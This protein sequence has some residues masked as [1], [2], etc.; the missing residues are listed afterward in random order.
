MFNPHQKQHLLRMEE[1]LPGM[2]IKIC[3]Y[4]NHKITSDK[5][6]KVTSLPWA[7]FDSK[8]GLT[9]MAFYGILEGEAEV[10]LIRTK[11]AYLDMTA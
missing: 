3:D 11:Y 9:V 6:C 7:E 5:S 10:T 8:H 2:H 4:T 1:L